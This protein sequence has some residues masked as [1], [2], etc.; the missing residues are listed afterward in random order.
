[1]SKIE[2]IVIPI[3]MP[4]LG[5]M[6]GVFVSFGVGGTPLAGFLGGLAVGTSV[7][8]LLFLIFFG[9][10]GGTSSYSPSSQPDSQVSEIV[11][12]GKEPSLI[13]EELRRM[14]GGR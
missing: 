10:G 4:L 1:M 9:M 6:L 8:L 5:A 13:V 3:P 14:T 11:N 7:M 2:R 12:S